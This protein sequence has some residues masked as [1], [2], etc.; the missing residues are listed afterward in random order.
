MNYNQYISTDPEVLGGRPCIAGTRISVGLILEQLS[1]GATID[2]LLEQYPD[3]LTR[4]QI[5][6]A[7]AFASER[8][9]EDRI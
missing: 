9:D 8:M 5:L 2:Y 7:L 4:E 1:F 3:L 6:A